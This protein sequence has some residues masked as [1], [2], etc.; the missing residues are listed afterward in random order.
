MIL[1]T[2]A[3]PLAI[4]PYSNTSRVV[5]W[6]TRNCGRVS[7]LIKGSQ[8]KKSRFLG[9][10]EIGH[11]SQLLFYERRREGLQIAKECG[12]KTP[13]PELTRDWRKGLTALYFSNL[14]SRTTPHQ[15]HSPEMFN[16]LEETLDL[17]A[18]QGGSRPFIFWRELTFLRREG[19]S[20]HLDHCMVCKNVARTLENRSGLSIVRGGLICND[21]ARKEGLKT[22]PISLADQN[23]LRGWQMARTTEAARQVKCTL[24]Q[25]GRIEMLLGEFLSYHLE[26]SSQS[27]SATLESLQQREKYCPAN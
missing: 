7:T 10:Y 18:Q 22:H 12:L 3:I 1:K 13:R 6:L 27:R 8:R 2:L 19:H 16:R 4:Y 5:H 25:I 26:I 11:T 17:I 9:Q 15:A 20:P 14:F 23:L 24:K 21:C